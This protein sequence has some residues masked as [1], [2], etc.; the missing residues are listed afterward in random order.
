MPGHLVALL[1]ILSVSS[2]VEGA[3]VGHSLMA[4]EFAKSRLSRASLPDP[5]CRSGLISKPL[6]PNMKQV[7]CPSYCGECS[8]YPTCSSVRGQA[9]ENACCASKVKAMECGQGA[10]AN[11]CLKKCTESL[12]PCIMEEGTVWKKPDAADTAAADCNKAVEDWHLKVEA[13]LKPPVTLSTTG[14]TT[15]PTT[16][17]VATTTPTTTPP[18]KCPDGQM[19]KDNACQPIPGNMMPTGVWVDASKNVFVNDGRNHQTLMYPEGFKSAVLV[20]GGNGKGSAMNQMN[21]P[22]ALIVHKGFIYVAEWSNYLVAK[23]PLGGPMKKEIVAGGNGNGKALNQVSSIMNG[24]IFD[25]DD[26]MYI[27]D[28][29][30]CRVMKFPK[31]STQSTMGEVIAGTGSFDNSGSLSGMT[32]ASGIQL[33]SNGNLYVADVMNRR[34]MFFAKGSKSGDDGEVWAQFPTNI[35]S[36]AWADN[37][38][39]AL[40]VTGRDNKLYKATKGS[41]QVMTSGGKWGADGGI[42]TDGSGNLYASFNQ[43]STVVKYAL[44]FSSYA[45]VGK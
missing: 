42:A 29:H 22:M 2:S 44:D 17:A 8:D 26:N 7:C 25:A 33:D 28:L 18:P 14:P 11:V 4:K 23:W 36:V 30:G 24:I 34:I 19:Y 9:S 40:Y 41:V 39:D 45:T 6:M 20:A 27:G 1:C 12:P 5:T 13:A 3:G 43:G 38:R 15:V 31:G 37:N 21:Y 32:Q 10:P 35:D 16:T